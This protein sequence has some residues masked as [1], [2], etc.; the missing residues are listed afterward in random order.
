MKTRCGNTL[1]ARGEE[2]LARHLL[3]CISIIII[4]GLASVRLC[5]DKLKLYEVEF[6]HVFS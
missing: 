1:T 4:F 3:F 6:V 5:D 2:K